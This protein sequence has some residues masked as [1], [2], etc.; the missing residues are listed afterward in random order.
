MWCRRPGT[1]V[2]RGEPGPRRARHRSA[3]TGWSCP[4]VLVKGQSRLARDERED[5]AHLLETDAHQ[6]VCVAPVTLGPQDVEIRLRV[7]QRLRAATDLLQTIVPA[8]AGQRRRQLHRT[9]RG[10]TFVDLQLAV[11][12]G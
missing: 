5:L 7:A 10:V 4:G 1:R 11:Q 9:E 8:P 12:V 6:E 3:V 2:H